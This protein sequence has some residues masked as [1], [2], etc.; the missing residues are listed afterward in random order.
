MSVEKLIPKRVNSVSPHFKCEVTSSFS[1][2]CFLEPIHIILVFSQLI[3]K[4]EIDPK[5]SSKFSAACRE[6]MVPFN[7]SVVSSANCVILKEYFPVLIPITSGVF[8]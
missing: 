3:F 6:Q 7:K 8:C 2:E 1:L 5:T 4:P